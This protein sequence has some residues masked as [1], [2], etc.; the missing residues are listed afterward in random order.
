D[1]LAGL[2]VA[3]FLPTT[4]VGD[5]PGT[6]EQ[7]VLLLQNSP[8]PF[9]NASTISYSVTSPGHVSL[10]LYDVLGRP[11]RQL[12]DGPQAAG[13]HTVRLEGEGLSSG[14]YFYQLNANGTRERRRCTIIR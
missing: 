9:R 3:G 13:T 12:V 11:V 2:G 7:P 4:G 14:V 10:T 8:N 1:I 5:N 6:A